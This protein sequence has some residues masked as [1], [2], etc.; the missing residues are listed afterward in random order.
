LRCGYSVYDVR[1]LPRVER[2]REKAYRKDDC[3]ADYRPH[4]H[5]PWVDALLG[6]RVEGAE[7]GESDADLEDF[8]ALVD[9]LRERVEDGDLATA[10]ELADELWRDAVE[11]MFVLG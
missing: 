11:T 10:R 5:A 7:G 2:V 8:A 1:F 3:L 6:G 9:E 4:A